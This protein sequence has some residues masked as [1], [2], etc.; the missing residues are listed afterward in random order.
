MVQIQTNIRKWIDTFMEFLESEHCPVH[1][2]PIILGPKSVITTKCVFYNVEQL[3]RTNELRSVISI[4][5]NPNCVEVWD[6]S[7]ANIDILA[8][9]GIIA[10]H[11]PPIL[12]LSFLSK[13]KK[14]REEGQSYDIG[15]SGGLTSKRI[16]IL[17]SLKS[18]GYKVNYIRD[19][20][21]NERDKEIAK[22]RVLLNIHAGEDY[23]IFECARCEPWLAIGVPIIS[24]HSL[25]NDSRCINVEYSEIVN[26]VIEVLTEMGVSPTI[27]QKEQIQK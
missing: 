6:Y 19:L 1:E 10:R 25:D 5:K 4:V 14:F 20:F 15:F 18:S 27:A 26:K 11:V 22:C 12:P 24:E 17:D 9:Q 2:F 16:H 7:L 23:K 13:L 21:G 8:K 3:T